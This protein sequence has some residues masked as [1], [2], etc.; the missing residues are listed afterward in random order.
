MKKT[1][2][3]LLLCFAFSA[4]AAS[5]E[6]SARVL[7]VQ[8]KT[9]QSNNRHQV[10]DGDQ[11]T[12]SG[13][14]VGTLIGAVAGGLLGAQ[15]GQGN[16]RVAASAGGAVVGALTGNHLE[17]NNQGGRNCYMADDYQTRVVG[18]NV[19]YEYQGR[20][21]TDFFQNA[22]NGDTIK[23]RVNLTPSVSRY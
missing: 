5:F 3:A 14:G 4:N 13:P 12:S 17:N 21:F 23:V 10:C 8:E 19:S 18:Y 9:T 20:T 7:S 16:G 22:P 1:T 11:A 6:D 2:I 15:V